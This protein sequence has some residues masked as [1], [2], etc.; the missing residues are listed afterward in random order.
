[1]KAGSATLFAGVL[2]GISVS[3][4]PVRVRVEHGRVSRACCVIRWAPSFAAKVVMPCM[5][6]YIW[7]GRD[8]D[9]DLKRRKQFS[10]SHVLRESTA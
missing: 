10:G 3:E 8:I 1:V 4:L 7:G 9:A 2:E 6:D 5:H